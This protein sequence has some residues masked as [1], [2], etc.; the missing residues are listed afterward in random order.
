MAVLRRIKEKAKKVLSKKITLKRKPKA[1]KVKES[2][3]KV[4]KKEI[5]GAQETAIGTVKFSHPETT[6]V[7]RTLD[8]KS[9]V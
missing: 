1:T 7:H 4:I 8:R 6:R 2:P 3:K 9:V 5:L